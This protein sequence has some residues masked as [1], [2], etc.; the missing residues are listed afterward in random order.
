[1]LT[2]P[3]MIFPYD[4][5]VGHFLVGIEIYDRE[6][7][8]GESLWELDP[9]SESRENIIRA[10]IIPGLCYLSYR[11]KYLLFSKLESSLKDKGFDFSVFLA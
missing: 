1:M 10:Y 7:T 3:N 2:H 9:N 5:T 4:P 8:L 11:H 6:E